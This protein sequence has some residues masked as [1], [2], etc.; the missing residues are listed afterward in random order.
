MDKNCDSNTFKDLGNKFY[1]EKCYP[2]A[3]KQYSFGILS[4]SGFTIVRDTMSNIALASWQIK[5][6]DLTLYYCGN[7]L[8]L[9]PD[10]SKGN[11]YRVLSL[12]ALYFYNEADEALAYQREANR[13]NQ[14]TII[15]SFKQQAILK[16]NVEVPTAIKSQYECGV[17]YISD[18]I[19]RRQ[20]QGNRIG[21][22][23]T[24]P[25]R[26]GM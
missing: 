26:Q 25:I 7:V 21:L 3:V 20:R 10:H 4:H 5:K 8:T 6:Y 23:T 11:H 17:D 14:K 19:E 16:G 24:K 15:A 22:F 12:N 1:K 2:E 9:T 18:K 13:Q